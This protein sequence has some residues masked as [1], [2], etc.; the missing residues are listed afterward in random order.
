MLRVSVGKHQRAADNAH[1]AEFKIFSA[2]F[3][4]DGTLVSQCHPATEPNNLSSS[5]NSVTYR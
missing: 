4:D 1:Q 5:P 3:I 2:S